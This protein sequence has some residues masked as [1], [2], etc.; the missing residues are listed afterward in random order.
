VPKAG[1]KLAQAVHE[2]A[3]PASTSAIPCLGGALAQTYLP[4]PCGCLRFDISGELVNIAC[5]PWRWTSG[6]FSD[7][8][9]NV[10]LTRTPLAAWVN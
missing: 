4:L 5:Q 1:F 8:A 2:A 9:S 6:S 10:S 3:V 7:S